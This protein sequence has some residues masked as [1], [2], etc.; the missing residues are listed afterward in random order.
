MVVYQQLFEYSAQQEVQLSGLL[1]KQVSLRRGP[2]LALAV[3]LL[4]SPAS[5]YPLGTRYRGSLVLLDPCVFGG[6][7]GIKQVLDYSGS[8]ILFEIKFYSEKL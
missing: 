1:E 7:A 6:E 5:Q 2:V 4:S 3:T 8:T